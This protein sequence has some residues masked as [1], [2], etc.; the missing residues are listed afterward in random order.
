[1][2]TQSEDVSPHVQSRDIAPP[3]A[4]DQVHQQGVMLAS[5]IGWYNC[6]CCH[7]KTCLFKKDVMENWIDSITGL[8]FP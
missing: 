1:M 7:M 4:Q 3:T 6:F 5:C 8:F 2:G